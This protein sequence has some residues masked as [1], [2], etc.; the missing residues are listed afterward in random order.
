MRCPNR[1]TEVGRV[2]GRMAASSP[3]QARKGGFIQKN[4]LTKAA[5][6]FRRCLCCVSWQG[7]S[8]DVQ[9]PFQRSCAESLS[10]RWG[11][12]P[13]AS[14]YSAERVL[15]FTLNTPQSKWSE[16]EFQQILLTPQ[17][18][19]K[20]GDAALIICVRWC[21]LKG[22]CKVVFD[23][24]MEKLEMSPQRLLRT[25]VHTQLQILDFFGTFIVAVCIFGR[26]FILLPLK[27]LDPVVGS[28]V[29]TS[30]SWTG[31][32]KST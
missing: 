22:L 4:A 20:S 24:S 8:S 3:H 12:S 17:P 27:T 15:L 31:S 25:T 2:S 14:L 11:R 1:G 6:C 13:P 9:T 29:T 30:T 10:L 18:Q 21:A 26:L 32:V 23:M 16:L 28:C 7:H 19:P 5:W